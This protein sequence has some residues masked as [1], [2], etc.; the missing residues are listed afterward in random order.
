MHTCSFGEFS[1]FMNACIHADLP[2]FLYSRQLLLDTFYYSWTV[3]LNPFAWI[4]ILMLEA[5][6][7]ISPCS[8]HVP[9]WIPLHGYLTLSIFLMYHK[10]LMSYVTIE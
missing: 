10:I 5:V 3:M 8:C 1:E 2:S 9:L 6:D 4:I 7:G